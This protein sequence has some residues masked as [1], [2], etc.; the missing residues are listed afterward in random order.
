MV[1]VTNVNEAVKSRYGYA[2]TVL[3]GLV[4]TDFKLRYQG[5]FLG[6]AWSVLRPLMVFAVMYVVF[7]RFLKISDGTPTYPVVLLCGVVSWQFVTETV[8]M[9]LRSIVDRGDLL[10]KV[11]FP[12][13]IVVVSASLGA[14]ISLA[15]NFVVVL[16][17]AFFSHVQF[18]WE[19]LWLPLNLI[20]LYV[21]ALSIAMICATC[22]VYFRDIAHIWDVV[23]QILFYCMPIMYP[24]S[25]VLTHAGTYG[26]LVARVE[27]LNP[28][29]QCIQD[30]R[31]NF[32]A[33]ATTPTVWNMFSNPWA[34]AFPIAVTLLL[35]WFGVWLFRRNS[36][37]FAEVI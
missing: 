35:A 25:Y 20:Q 3:R 2:M 15:I 26:E 17:F 12:N 13:V 5:S 29:A 11:H 8:T 18:T 16:V 22:Y 6:V 9:G 23:Q 4:K 33:P 24:L 21:L 28:I 30:I 37:K 10:R 7:A 36:S 32:L 14:L 34:K 1:R 27:V 31:H 19:V